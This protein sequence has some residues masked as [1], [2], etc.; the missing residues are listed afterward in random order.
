M[1][2]KVWTVRGLIDWMAADF[3]QKGVDSPRLDAELLLA[4][5]LKKRRVELYLGLD[6]IVEDE[7]ALVALR[8]LVSRRRKREPIAYILGVKA[9]YGRDFKVNA[10]VLIPRPDSETLVAAALGVAPIGIQDAVTE[11]ESDPDDVLVTVEQTELVE[12]ETSVVLDDAE[13]AQRAAI[14][15]AAL[16]E[17]STFVPLEESVVAEETSAS[18]D[19]TA[20]AAA[21]LRVLDLCTGSGII[22]LTIAAEQRHATVTLTDVS[23]EALAVAAENA[24]ALQ[25]SDRVSL[26]CGDLFSALPN[27]ELFDLITANPPYIDEEG[28][29]HLSKDIADHEP[30][31]AL[32]G[33]TQGLELVRKIIAGARKYLR[34]G[35][36]LH[37]EIGI[38]QAARVAD[39]M[40]RAGFVS[41]C[42]TKDL[43]R[44]ERV[45]SGVWEGPK[46]QA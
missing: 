12:G 43:G 40:N 18:S 11:Y 36:M 9:F 8:Q 24:Q 1:T 46:P 45:V 19:E 2:D 28:M 16:V 31:L 4:K 20:P 30:R 7:E 35:G 27:D 22:G 34:K 6:D 37:L 23:K 26:Y 10:S 21:P 25:L 17:E 3:E 33:G 13:E 29:K 14:A 44:I 38:G 42:S 39:W 41:V 5:A 32:F 15:R